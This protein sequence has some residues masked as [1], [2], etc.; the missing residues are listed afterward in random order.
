[1]SVMLRTSILL[2]VAATSGLLFTSFGR[3]GPSESAVSPAIH[4]AFQRWSLQNNRLYG[5]PS[6]LNYRFS[7]FSENYAEVEKLK[8]KVTHEVG[9]TIFADLTKEEF[10]TKYLGFNGSPAQDSPES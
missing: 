7:I 3:A 1:M 2:A 5:T 10:A 4:E 8:S 6:E 9:L